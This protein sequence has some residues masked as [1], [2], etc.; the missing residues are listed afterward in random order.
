M[1]IEMHEFFEF[2]NNVDK[3]VN[4]EPEVVA[5]NFRDTL[6]LMRQQ[7]LRKL[8][9]DTASVSP[10]IAMRSAFDSAPQSHNR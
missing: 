9:Q 7:L 4:A 10:A 8:T 5:C 6:L 3:N 1:S 2:V